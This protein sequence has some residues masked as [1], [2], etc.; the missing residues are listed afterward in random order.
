[1]NPAYEKYLQLIAMTQAQRDAWAQDQDIEDLIQMMAELTY[2][3]EFNGQARDESHMDL[4]QANQVINRIKG[5][6]PDTGI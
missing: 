4:T 5:N 2:I 3:L 6:I 1:M